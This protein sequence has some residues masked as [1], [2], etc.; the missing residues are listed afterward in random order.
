MKEGS[1]GGAQARRGAVPI[2]VSVRVRGEPR[3]PGS[4]TGPRPASRPFLWLGSSRFPGRVFLPRTR[5]ARCLSSL[6]AESARRPAGGARVTG[7]PWPRPPSATRDFWLRGSLDPQPPAP[8]IAATLR[9]VWSGSNRSPRWGVTSQPET[10]RQLIPQLSSHLPL[11]T[12]PAHTPGASRAT[13]SRFPGA[14]RAHAPSCTRAAAKTRVPLA[15][16]PRERPSGPGTARSEVRTAAKLTYVRLLDPKGDQRHEECAV[17]AGKSEW[18]SGPG[19][20]PFL[21]P[22]STVTLGETFSATSVSS[23]VT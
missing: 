16:S 19:F 6:G 20:S 13:S 8:H 5:G 21:V 22:P 18:E 4:P 1:L 7:S 23:P 9:P 17:F 2:C 3:G 10:N 11:T 15:D 12:G 14:Q